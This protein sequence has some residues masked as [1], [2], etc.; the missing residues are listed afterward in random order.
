MLLIVL[1]IHIR[2]C[3]YVMVMAKL[4]F[5][6]FY[7][8]IFLLLDTLFTHGPFIYIMSY[9]L[10]VTIIVKV[11]KYCNNCYNIMTKH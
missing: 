9:I 3:T 8:W 1:R 2:T 4:I 7:Y 11:Q 6:F 5:D 10:I